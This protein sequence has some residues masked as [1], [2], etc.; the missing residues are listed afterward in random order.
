MR[1]VRALDQLGQLVAVQDFGPV[2]V[3]QTARRLKGEETSLV[4]CYQMP[5]SVDIRVSLQINGKLT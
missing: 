3:V 5:F 1:Q 4:V 2:R